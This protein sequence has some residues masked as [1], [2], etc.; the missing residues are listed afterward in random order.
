[1]FTKH[2]PDGQGSRH[3]DNAQLEEIIARYQAR[4]DAG[5]LSEIIRLTRDRALTLIRFHKTTRYGSE[6]ELLSDVHFKL[7]R[8]VDKF[9]YSKGSAF[10]FVSRVVT[11][12]LCTSVSNARRRSGRYVELDEALASDLPANGE[13]AAIS[14]RDAIEDLMHRI[15]SRARSTISDPGELDTQR[16]YVN[17]F[18]EDGFESRRH[19]CANAAQAV[20]GVSHSRSRELYDLSML[21]CRRLLFDDLPPRPLIAAGRLLGTRAAWM[22]RYSPLMNDSEFTKFVVLAKDLSPF[23]LLLVDPQSRSRRQDRNPAI[24]RQNLEWVIHGH[25]DAVPLF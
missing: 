16:W 17:S 21:E 25:P 2:N 11:N 19:E 12:A 7:L 6:A 8:A 9:D 24:G 1:M 10:T 13:S 3:L 5:S 14:G 22:I 20:H 18:C 15:R 23:V 4:G